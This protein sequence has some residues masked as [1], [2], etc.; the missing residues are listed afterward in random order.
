V[1]SSRPLGVLVGLLRWHALG[2]AAALILWIVAA[3]AGLPWRLAFW[4][5]LGWSV[6][7]LVHYLLYKSLI[8][9][10]RWAAERVEELNLKSYDRGH[11][12]TIKAKQPGPAGDPSRRQ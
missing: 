4:P 2:F 10:E 11:I 9:D 1:T 3:L 8:V 7:L 5:M 12:E 6:A